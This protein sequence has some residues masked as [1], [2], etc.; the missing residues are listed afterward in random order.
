MKKI[1]AL[2]LT[3]AMAGC[4]FCGCNRPDPALHSESVPE[5]NGVLRIST[6]PDFAPMVFVDP[7]KSG[8]DQFVGFDITLAKFIAE[9]LN[10][11]LEIMPMDFNSCQ[12][13]VYAGTVD[14]SISGY[15]WSAE[16]EEKYSLS[17]NYHAGNSADSQV[18]ITLAE[19]AERYATAE[20]LVGAL[21][22]AQSASLQQLLVTEQLPEAELH[23]FTDLDLAVLMLLNGDFDCIAVSE[24]NAEAIIAT[25]ENVTRTG[26]Q[27]ELDERHM[28]NVILLNKEN[29]ELT[30]QVNSILE[31]ASEYYDEWY[32]QAKSTAGIQVTYDSEGNVVSQSDEIE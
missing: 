31:K 14:M 23:L 8:Q 16:R 5:R 13:A 9:E 29:Q 25:H 19:N 6:S 22:G 7:T 20:G 2:I 32:I 1:I 17:D 21:M 15:A 4:V 11:E 3:L 26:F 12:M 27:F 10:M 18:I 28:G 24:G 30:E